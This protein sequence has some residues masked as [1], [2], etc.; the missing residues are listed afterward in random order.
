MIDK[1]MYKFFG[2]IDS[3]FEKLDDVLTYDIGQENK[4]KN[5]KK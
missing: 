3:L 2:W 4:K 1:I 5:K